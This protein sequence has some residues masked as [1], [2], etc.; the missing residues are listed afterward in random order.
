MRRVQALEYLCAFYLHIDLL[1]GRTEALPPPLLAG[2]DDLS[3]SPA[4]MLNGVD[5]GIEME[6]WHFAST[7]LP[8]HVLNQPYPAEHSLAPPQRAFLCLFQKKF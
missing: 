8:P 7:R 1:P 5:P 2:V 6:V 3:S 4:S